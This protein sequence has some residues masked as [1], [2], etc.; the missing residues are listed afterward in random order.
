MYFL[1]SFTRVTKSKLNKTQSILFYFS[2]KKI[3]KIVNFFL[4]SLFS[5]FFN[6][7][8]VTKK[9]NFNQSFSFFIFFILPFF[10]EK[11][12]RFEFSEKIQLTE[13]EFILDFFPD[14]KPCTRLMSFIKKFRF[15]FLC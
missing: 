6:V 1:K 2:L 13:Y 8:T 14:L 3:Q 10:F 11:Q 5:V 4:F 12:Y 9:L 7:L 15:Y